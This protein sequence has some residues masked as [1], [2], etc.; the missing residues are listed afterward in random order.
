MSIQRF[1]VPVLDLLLSNKFDIKSLPFLDIPPVVPVLLNDILVSF[2][3]GNKQ[4]DNCFHTK[5]TIMTLISL[6]AYAFNTPVECEES[7]SLGKIMIIN[8][9][10]RECLMKD[11][12]LFNQLIRILVFSI[13]SAFGSPRFNTSQLQEACKSIYG[14][15]CDIFVGIMGFMDYFDPETKEISFLV[16]CVM[17]DYLLNPENRPLIKDQNSSSIIIS[18]FVE[19]ASRLSS[20]KNN[21]WSKYSFIWEKWSSSPLFNFLW[22]IQM[23]SICR[24]YIDSIFI[25]KDADF[26]EKEYCLNS[27]SR[28]F[29]VSRI[30]DFDSLQKQLSRLINSVND[31][32]TTT[33]MHQGCVLIPRFPAGFVASFLIDISIE[34]L[35]HINSTMLTKEVMLLFS[36]VGFDQGLQV[37]MNNSINRIKDIVKKLLKSLNDKDKLDFLRSLPLFEFI[38]SNINTISI[39]P[40]LVPFFIEIKTVSAEILVSA[41]WTLISFSSIPEFSISST[42][43]WS[44]KSGS[45]KTSDNESSEEVASTI[46]QA[47]LPLLW[48]YFHIADSSAFVQF[49]KMLTIL[50]FAHSSKDLLVSFFNMIS[51]LAHSKN[52][53]IV[54]KFFNPDAFDR[55]SAKICEMP[56]EVIIP[57]MVAMTEVSSVCG[58]SLIPFLNQNKGIFSQCPELLLM[59]SESR[60][61]KFHFAPQLP[62][63]N[64][65]GH[66]YINEKF[67][68][69][70]EQEKGKNSFILYIRDMIGT[71]ILKIQ[72]IVNDSDKIPSLCE[73]PSPPS[74]STL[75]TEALISMGN[76]QNR[77]LNR[78]PFFAQNPKVCLGEFGPTNINRRHPILEVLRILDFFSYDIDI[79]IYLHSNEISTYLSQL[80]GVEAVSTLYIPVYYASLA[81]KEFLWDNEIM[82]S[83]LQN[84]AVLGDDGVFY[85]NAKS[86]RFA[87]IPNSHPNAKNCPLSIIFNRMNQA[88][89][90]NC[91][92]E[93]QSET[94]I[95]IT[96]ISSS[97]FKINL[98]RDRDGSKKTSVFDKSVNVSIHDLLSTIAYYGYSSVSMNGGFLT[99]KMRARKEIIERRPSNHIDAFDLI[100]C[101]D[102]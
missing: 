39:L 80:D 98:L 75:K 27:F 62:D 92:S 44:Y 102:N 96:P 63:Q 76:S 100:A 38:T 81:S 52:G 82:Q 5:E 3:N 73:F 23:E 57:W 22:C 86:I 32:V 30:E 71:S 21:L 90:M 72:E 79:P 12:Q 6:Y 53:D 87:F 31:A 8:I 25:E 59:L 68:T 49:A 69:V 15:V 9:L 70:Y 91:I 78:E 101:A 34:V 17:I 66:F 61:K 20:S 13:T 89:N 46:T 95:S 48:L 93:I 28:V 1:T 77:E 58:Y 42:L 29:N 83:F 40:E 36:K 7:I 67:Y 64:P 18:P 10:K 19:Q 43:P 47:I 94:L 37:F 54:A 99:E 74:V 4:L 16:S 26:L 55:F 97:V 45:K 35:S 88:I 84:F 65:C 11:S 51:S 14:H 33:C 2:Y 85:Y 56:K 50:D 24:G 41:L 60:F